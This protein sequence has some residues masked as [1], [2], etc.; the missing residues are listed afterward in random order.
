MATN[1]SYP[2]ANLGHIHDVTVVKLVKHSRPV[3]V[4]SVNALLDQ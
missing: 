1:L 2:H 3:L 4:V